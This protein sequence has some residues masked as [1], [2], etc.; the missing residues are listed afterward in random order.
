MKPEKQALRIGAAALLCALLLRLFTSGTFAQAVSAL[1]SPELISFVLYLETGRLYRPVV[2]E[3]ATTPETVE[4]TQTLPEETLPEID[5]PAQAV[6]APEDALLVDVN[7]VCGYPADTQALLGQPLSWDL[8]ASEPTV[9]ILHSHATESY[10]NTENYTPSGDYRTL[11]ANYNMVSV[12]AYLTQLL[13]EAG[14]NVLHDT[15][16]HDYPSY[17]NSYNESR[18]AAKAY[19]EQYTS[20]RLV[21]DL[22][23]DSVAT[24]SGKQLGYTVSTSQGTAAQLML[25]VGTNA[26]GLNHPNWYENLSLAVKLHAQLEKQ[27][28]GICRPISFRSQRFNQDLSPGALLIEVGA[29]GNTRQEA[30]LAA[31]H[32][33]QT[34]LSM[35]GGAITADPTS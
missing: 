13:E 15:T 12:G 17:S 24:T 3:D 8:T 26:S 16:L 14:V 33:A 5:A 23:R 34:I 10:E 11:D 1:S 18:S 35:S 9:L 25:V 28:P 31:Q 27:C 21:L 30:L 32:L 22:H 19:L 7:S 2:P 6:F 4:Q 20:I 29:A